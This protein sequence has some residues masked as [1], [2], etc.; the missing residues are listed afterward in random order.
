[1]QT[2]PAI[3]RGFAQIDEGQVHFRSAGTAGGAHLPLIMFHASPGSA[4]MLEPL[5]RAMATDRMAIALD[6]LGNGDSVAPAP[7]APDVAYYADAHA[8][9]LDALGIGRCDVYGAHTGAALAIEFAVTRPDRVRRLVLD[10]ISNYT[11]AERADML[12]H[13]A[14]PIAIDLHG[15]YLNWIWHFVRDGYVFW[16]WYK[17]SA[18]N[19]RDIG[20][21]SAATL[22]EKV[23]EVLKA[24]RT[25]HLS[26]RAAIAYPR[27]E[28]LPL[29]RQSALC[30]C[31]RNDMLLPYLETAAAMI[32]AATTAITPAVGSPEALQATAAIFRQFLDRAP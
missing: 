14:P 32:P 23:L 6:T 11:D 8:R 1:M 25:Y 12:A 10:G 28:R 27:S 13:H 18:A 5:I 16:P 20:L 9:A 21:P 15:A 7:A 2:N 29:L 31:A 3:R 19:L 30:A 4:K 17:K 26:Y 24:A 22:Y